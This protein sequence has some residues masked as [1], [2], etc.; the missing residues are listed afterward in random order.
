LTSKAC[1]EER[2]NEALNILKK[3]NR[4]YTRNHRLI[5]EIKGNLDLHWRRACT[6]KIQELMDSMYGDIKN[7]RLYRKVK[8]S[9]IEATNDWTKVGKGRIS[10]HH[11]ETYERSASRVYENYSDLVDNDRRLNQEVQKAQDNLNKELR[12]G[13]ELKGEISSDG[14]RITYKLAAGSYL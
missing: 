10:I 9:L 4:D 7:S 3:W 11:I 12:N 6:L 13:R 1:S 5:K 8:A 14:I 2:C